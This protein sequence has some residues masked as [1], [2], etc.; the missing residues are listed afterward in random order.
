MQNFG[1]DISWNVSASGTELEMREKCS[2][3]FEGNMLQVC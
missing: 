3:S 1:K 2:N